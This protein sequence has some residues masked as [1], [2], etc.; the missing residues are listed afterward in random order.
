MYVAPEFRRAKLGEQLIDNAKTVAEGAGCSIV[1]LSTPPDG[2]RA[3]NFYRNV[4]FTQ[5]GV[6]MRHKFD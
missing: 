1:E 6:R 5:V 4:G 2:E 3:Q